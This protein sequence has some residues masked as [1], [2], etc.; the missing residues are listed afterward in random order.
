MN[1]VYGILYCLEQARFVRRQLSTGARQRL[2]GTGARCACPTAESIGDRHSLN[3]GMGEETGG[4][5]ARTEKALSARRREAT[6]PLAV[7]NIC[8]PAH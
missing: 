1:C 7:A 3:C 8:S 6:E 5:K 4:E 2:D